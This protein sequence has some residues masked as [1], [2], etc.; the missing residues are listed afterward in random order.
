MTFD[1]LK[2]YALEELVKKG[3]KI[4]TP[5]DAVDLFQKKVVTEQKDADKHVITHPIYNYI[6]E[7]L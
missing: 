3:Y 6:M 1:P 4:D 5:W 7:K 2:E